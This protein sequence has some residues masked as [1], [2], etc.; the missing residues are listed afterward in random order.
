MADNRK[1]YRLDDDV[2][3]LLSKRKESGSYGTTENDVVNRLLKNVPV[4]E[5]KLLDASNQFTKQSDELTITRKKLAESDAELS[6]LTNA[7]MLV[8]SYLNPM[9]K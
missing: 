3:D 9:G 8:G 5:K 1:T 6:K 2:A 4:L 7:L